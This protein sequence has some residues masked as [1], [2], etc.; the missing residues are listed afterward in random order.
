MTKCYDVSRQLLNH[1]LLKREWLLGA[2]IEVKVFL[3]AHHTHLYTY[4]WHTRM[5][6][7]THTT[8]KYQLV[9]NFPP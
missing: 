4:T 7:H 3:T 9:S 6:V 5:Y 8:W 2:Y 1:K